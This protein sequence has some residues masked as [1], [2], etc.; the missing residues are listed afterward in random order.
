MSEKMTKFQQNITAGNSTLAHRAASLSTAA[1]IAQE[2]LI[3]R[4]KA[5]ISDRKLKLQDK[6]DF[7]PLTSD[8]LRPEKPSCS[9][10]E[11]AKD[12]QSLKWEI[13]QAEE[14]LKIAQRTYDE[15]FTDLAEPATK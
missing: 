12:V 15:L 5:Q 6:L 1:A 7:A 14:Q 11:W 9:M 10:D 13:H 2:A 8:S 3:N 4:I